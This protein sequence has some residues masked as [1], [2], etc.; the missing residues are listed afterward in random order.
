MKATGC[1]II[2]YANANAEF[3]LYNISDIHWGSRGCAKEYLYRDIERIARN[4]YAIFFVGGDYIDFIMPGDPRF[5]PEAIDDNY[6]IPDLSHLSALLVNKLIELFRPISN[7]CMGWA[8]GNHEHKYMMKN[9]LMFIHNTLCETLNVPNFYF[10]GWCDIYFLHNP[11]LPRNKV[12]IKQYATAPPPG[13]NAKLRVFLH[14]GMGA[15]N[16]TGG[17]INK[18]EHLVNI[19]DGANLVFMGH[20][21]E[22]IAKV[23]P[24]LCSNEYCNDIYDHN[25]VGVVSGSYLRC[26]D[27]N[28][29]GYGETKGWRPTVLGATKAVYR[30]SDG[31][32]GALIGTYGVGKSRINP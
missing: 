26:Y 19:T 12:K 31:F 24:R 28:Y 3:S 15:A 23:F 22:Q 27:S 20:V 4:P 9:H 7:K 10:S 8:M 30:P 2:E 21:H 25:I 32:C 17:K 11:Q 1:R 16:T 5:D 6:T 29:I 13:Y 18:L 14:H